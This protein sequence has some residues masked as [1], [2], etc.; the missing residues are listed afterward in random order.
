MKWILT[1]FSR[2][3]ELAT[4]M[5]ADPRFGPAHLGRMM[6]ESRGLRRMADAVWERDLEERSGALANLSNFVKRDW[7]KA[8][9]LLASAGMPLDRDAS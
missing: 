1:M 6:R 2:A 8:L 3:M 5:A 4:A 7:D 9:K